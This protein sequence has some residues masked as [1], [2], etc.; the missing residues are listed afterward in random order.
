LTR[1]VGGI[2]AAHWVGG[3][4]GEVAGEFACGVDASN[5]FCGEI[6]AHCAVGQVASYRA[7][8]LASDFARLCVGDGASRFACEVGG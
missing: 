4:A 3:L 5:G 2:T 7:R 1:E 8:R 6:A